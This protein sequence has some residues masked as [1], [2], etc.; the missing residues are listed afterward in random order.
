MS[1]GSTTRT[2]QKARQQHR[3]SWCGQK[4]E[5]GSLYH[6]WRWFDDGDAS[7]VKMHDECLGAFERSGDNE[8]Y[9]YDN[10]RPTPDEACPQPSTP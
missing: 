6:R 3:C 5:P 4:I 9:L 8:F 10:E 1:C 2:T 7:T